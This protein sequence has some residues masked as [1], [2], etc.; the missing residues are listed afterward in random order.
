MAAK[1]KESI[2]KH[3]KSPNRPANLERQRAM[4]KLIIYVTSLAKLTRIEIRKGNR[5]L[6]PRYVGSIDEAI[7]FVLPLGNRHTELYVNGFRY[8]LYGWRK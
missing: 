7:A 8:D 5:W 4:K 2:S 6:K 1:T 3:R